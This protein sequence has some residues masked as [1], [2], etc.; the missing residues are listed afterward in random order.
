MLTPTARDGHWPSGR[1]GVDLGPFPRAPT[2][3]SRFAILL[4]VPNLALALE[5]ISLR[6]LLVADCRQPAGQSE[7][8]LPRHCRRS[9]GKHG[10][11]GS[12]R[13]ATSRDQIFLRQSNGRE[14]PRQRSSDMP[15]S[16]STCKDGAG[17]MTEPR[18]ASPDRESSRHSCGSMQSRP[19]RDRPL[20]DESSHHGLRTLCRCGRARR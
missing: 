11:T 1:T 17:R 7:W 6:G 20:T 12:I 5:R 13:E 16:L 18:P 9:R 10:P 2:H 4:T 14:Y 15:A 3:R 8:P 19:G